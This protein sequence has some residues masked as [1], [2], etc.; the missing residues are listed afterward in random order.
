VSIALE[1]GP[2][3]AAKLWP[4]IPVSEVDATVDEVLNAIHAF[5]HARM[6]QEEVDAARAAPDGTFAAM[7]AAMT[8]RCRASPGLAE[9]E[10]AKGL[11]R[12]DVLSDSRAFGG[13]RVEYAE[14]GEWSLRLALLPVAKE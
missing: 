7:V 12:V 11:R 1:G 4:S 3:L 8:A 14:S 9:V 5:F 6:N 10:W 2:P 13:L